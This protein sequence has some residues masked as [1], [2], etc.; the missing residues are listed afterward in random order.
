MGFAQTSLDTSV[1]ELFHVGTSGRHP[2]KRSWAI[3]LSRSTLPVEIRGNPHGRYASS[4]LLSPEACPRCVYRRT[5]VCIRT[6]ERQSGSEEGRRTALG[7]WQSAEHTEPEANVQ[8]P[9]AR[10]ER[11]IQDER[12]GPASGAAAEHRG[13]KRRIATAGARNER[14]IQRVSDP[15]GAPR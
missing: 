4:A 5:C 1:R 11:E 9:G 8:L 3:T 15:E 2:A 6:N 10:N 7:L 12:P 14:E 13:A